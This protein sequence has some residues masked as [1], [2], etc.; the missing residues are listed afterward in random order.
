MLVLGTISLGAA[1]A[2]TPSRIAF[3]GFVVPAGCHR[4]LCPSA[5]PDAPAPSS[6]AGPTMGLPDH[7]WWRCMTCSTATWSATLAK[8]FES[9]ALAQEQ[10]IIFDTALGGDHLHP[11]R[12]HREVQP[13][14]RANCWAA[15]R[16]NLG[17]PAGAGLVPGRRSLAAGG[18][19]RRSRSCSSGG[20]YRSPHGTARAGT[21]RRFRCEISGT[22]RRSRPSPNWAP[23]GWDGTS[24]RSCRPRRRCAASEERFRDLLVAVVRL[25][26]GAGPAISASC[27]LRAA[28]R[29]ASACPQD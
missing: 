2:L 24:P 8:R 14:L 21:A 27:A 23:S 26:L 3:Y 22:R 19:R 12:P 7:C 4:A 11:R 25:V 9:D 6:A 13:A 17:R 18:A 5:S 20:T 10:Q 1:G 15:C 16:P 29:N 28:R